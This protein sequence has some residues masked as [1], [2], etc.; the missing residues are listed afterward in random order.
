RRGVRGYLAVSRGLIAVGCGDARTARKFADEAG[1][2]APDEP[3]TLLLSAQASQLAG[4]RAAAER[5]FHV[6]ANREDTR[7]LGLH[8]LFIEAQRRKDLPAAR[9]HAEAAAK[10]AP[11]RAGPEKS[12]RPPGRPIRIPI[13]PTL[14]RIWCRA[15]PRAT[16]SGAS[17]RWRARPRDMSKARSRSRA[18]RS[19]HR[20]FPSRARRWRRC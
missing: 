11:A 3:L 10:N 14:L 1:R 4:D 19:T 2:I 7:L 16:G 5:T 12:S 15:L 8:G 18:P 17:R 20:S 13:S 6:M 9:L